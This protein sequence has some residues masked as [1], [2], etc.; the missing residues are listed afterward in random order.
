MSDAL[1]TPP[2]LLKS[3]G[4]EAV[5][6]DTGSGDTHYLKPITL[7]VYQICCAHPGANLVELATALAAQ[8][9][10]FDPTELLDLTD[11][12]LQSLRKIHLLESA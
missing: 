4:D 7:M 11:D 10:V 1:L 5:V 3:W 6:Y 12:T 9:G 8:I 2:R